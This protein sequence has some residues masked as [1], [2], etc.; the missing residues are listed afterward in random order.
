[1][2]ATER[3]TLIYGG[4]CGPTHGAAEGYPIE[5]YTEL[6]GPVLAKADM[7]FVNCMRT[8][9]SRAVKSEL[10]PQVGQPVEMAAIYSN[11]QFD[12]VTMSNNH[13]CDA[14]FDAMLDTRALLESRG[15]QVTG[16]GKDLAEAR[17]AA[18][19]EKNGVR[20][21]YLGYTSVPAAG[22]EAG[23][24]KPGV[25]A[26]HVKTAYETRGPH[27]PVRIRTEPDPKGLAMLQE[28]IA[29]LR[30]EVDVVTLAYH[31]GVIRLPRV[32]ADYQVTVAHA[33]ID[34]G[35]DLVVGHSPHIPKA[36][37]V[38]KG[39]TIFYSIGVFA[40]TKS[41]PAPSWKQEPAWVH[42][43]VLNHVDLD[44]T[45]P[46]MPY[47]EPCTLALLAK[48]VA[49]KK[50][51]TRTSFVPMSFDARY[52]PEPLRRGDPRFERIVRYMEWA[53]VDMPHRFEVDGDEVVVTA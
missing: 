16:A 3:A 23:P 32:I 51:I 2:A 17:R 6:V 27:Q 40:M 5:G 49:T 53:S 50:G 18:I 52:R 14:G 46:L 8:Y 20:V 29:A 48:A 44:P 34:A 21:A 9:S 28:D 25:T 11:G 42:G 38:Y 36:I 24:K 35:A 13:V 26:I 1:M 12:A 43:S 10:A 15:I 30:R 37:E 31:A 45:F 4:D 33:A 47:G 22:S 41:F 7:R 39:K 19:I